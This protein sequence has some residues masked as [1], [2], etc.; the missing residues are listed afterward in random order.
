MEDLGRR[1]K[2]GRMTMQG[3]HRLLERLIFPFDRFMLSRGI[4]NGMM[5]RRKRRKGILRVMRR[6]RAGAIVARKGMRVCR[7]G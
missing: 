6:V 1:R 7:G 2:M 5:R 4:W 3:I